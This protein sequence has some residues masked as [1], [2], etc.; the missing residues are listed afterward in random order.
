MRRSLGEVLGALG[1]VEEARREWQI[2]AGLAP[3]AG[4]VLADLSLS[5]LD[6]GTLETAY[7]YGEK[8]V[9]ARP[10]RSR[11]RPR[12]WRR[13]NAGNWTA[14]CRRALRMISSRTPR[15]V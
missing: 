12:S 11:P 9:H 1:R 3:A 10:D 7:D 15:K 14:R 4:V 2:A 8:A 13:L 5:Y 6:E